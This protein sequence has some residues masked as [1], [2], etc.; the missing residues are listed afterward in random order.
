[1]FMETFKG[2]DVGKGVL[3]IRLVFSSF[4]FSL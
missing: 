2:C 4:F 1:M 3:A